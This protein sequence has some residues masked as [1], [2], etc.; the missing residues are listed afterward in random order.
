ML[1]AGRALS[2]KFSGAVGAA[3]CLG[4]N[5]TDGARGGRSEGSRTA[6][7]NA[8][9]RRAGRKRGGRSYRSHGVQNWCCLS[10]SAPRVCGRSNESESK[11]ATRPGEE[12]PRAGRRP[13]GRGCGPRLRL[14]TPRFSES[15]ARG[16][17]APPRPVGEGALSTVARVVAGGRPRQAK[18]VARTGRV[19]GKVCRDPQGS[20]SCARNLQEK[21]LQRPLRS[22]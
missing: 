15:A 6:R 21:V 12:S 7:E 4:T 10:P 1:G 3:Q 19:L 13:G 2:L 5:P 16:T 17:T 22:K 9:E 18:L 8:G 20:R 14:G 11:A